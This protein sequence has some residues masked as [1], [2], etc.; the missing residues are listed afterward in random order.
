[1]PHD[2]ALL[3]AGDPAARRE[4]LDTCRDYLLF[5]ANQELDA[6]LQGKCGPSDVVQNA[7]VKAVEHFDDFKGSS[8]HA[9]LAWLR[10]ILKN[11][12]IDVRRAYLDAEKRDLRKE[13]H[14]RA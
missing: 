5:I 11:E 1:M 6:R 3:L 4:I 8:Q 14:G 2:P 12:I 13:N 9:L 10:Q 7:M